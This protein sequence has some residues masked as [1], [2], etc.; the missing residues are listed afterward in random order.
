[1]VAAA[2]KNFEDC[3]VH[4][5][6]VTGTEF[7]RLKESKST[8]FQITQEEEVNSGELLVFERFGTDVQI[9]FECV[10][11]RNG[12]DYC[13]GDPQDLFLKRSIEYELY[14]KGEYK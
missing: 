3:K 7:Y 12:D 8:M 2:M 1:M 4:K 10:G 5:V 11:T 6:A 13:S 14:L 9:A